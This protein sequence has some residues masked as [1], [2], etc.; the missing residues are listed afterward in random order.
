MH[1]LDKYELCY[2][3]LI[4]LIGVMIKSNDLHDLINIHV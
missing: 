2:E 3:N 4:T 1:R